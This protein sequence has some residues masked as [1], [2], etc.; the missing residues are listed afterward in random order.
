MLCAVLER[1]L[2]DKTI[3][4]LRQGTGDFGR[5]PGARTVHE[6]LCALAGK[7]MAPLAQGGIGKVECVRDRLQTLALDDLAHGLGTPEA[8]GFFRLFEKG[9]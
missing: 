6:P 4:M 7:A 5:A 3:K 2:V 9:I 8:P 1:V